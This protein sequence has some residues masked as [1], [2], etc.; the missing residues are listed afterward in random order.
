MNEKVYINNDLKNY[1]RGLYENYFPKIYEFIMSS[2]SIAFNFKENYVLKNLL[3]L[4]DSILPE[5][6]SV[7][8]IFPSLS[9]VKA[10]GS[11][12]L[13]GIWISSKVFVIG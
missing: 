3:L 1:I 10:N 7:N 9:I 2:K 12:S 13:A 4:F 6:D 8:Q 11:D 5:Y